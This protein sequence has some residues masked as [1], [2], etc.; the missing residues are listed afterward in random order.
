MSQF[1]RPVNHCIKDFFI[2]KGE[3][4]GN[5]CVSA[6]FC[7]S[8]VDKASSCANFFLDW[9]CAVCKLA[10]FTSGLILVIFSCYLRNIKFAVNVLNFDFP[11]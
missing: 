4:L 10:C 7:F 6:K 1:I 8:W 5:D 3:Y 11:I 9:F 2:L